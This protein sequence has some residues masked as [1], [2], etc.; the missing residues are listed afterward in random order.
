MLKV[1]FAILMG[2]Q[3]LSKHEQ[4]NM[5]QVAIGLSN[6]HDQDGADLALEVEGWPNFE[7]HLLLAN[8]VRSRAGLQDA[9]TRS[10]IQQ[11]KVFSLQLPI[12]W[13]NI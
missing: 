3:I 12:A 4:F 2:N 13:S 6:W 8:D 10:L 9:R 1:S 5:A 11:G 7:H